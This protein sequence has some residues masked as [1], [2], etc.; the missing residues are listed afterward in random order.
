VSKT[1]DKLSC[2]GINKKTNESNKEKYLN[3][4][5]TKQSGAG[6]NKGFRVVSNAM[7]TYQQLRD[8]L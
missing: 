6:L 4:L 3:V 5:F 7:Y 1:K 2:K 8:G